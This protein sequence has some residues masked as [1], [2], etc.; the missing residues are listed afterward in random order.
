MPAG[1][2]DADRLRPAMRDVVYEEFKVIGIFAEDDTGL[3]ATRLNFEWLDKQRRSD[4][5]LQELLAWVRDRRRLDPDMPELLAW[6]REDKRR[7]EENRS[8]IRKALFGKTAEWIWHIVSAAIVGG[9]TYFF[10][11]RGH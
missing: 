7:T 8:E 4:T 3:R 1:E 5:D 9:V 6:L 10:I 11:S 2:I